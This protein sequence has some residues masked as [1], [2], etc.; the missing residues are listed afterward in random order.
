MKTDPVFEIVRELKPPKSLISSR[1]EFSV[2]YRDDPSNL[3]PIK[4]FL[5][6]EVLDNLNG[7]KDALPKSEDLQNFPL[8]VDQEMHDKYCKIYNGYKVAIYRMIA[9]KIAESKTKRA[10]IPLAIYISAKEYLDYTYGM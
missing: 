2:E 10:R 6:R 4:I 5:D 3:V 9:K 1:M 7:S 8:V